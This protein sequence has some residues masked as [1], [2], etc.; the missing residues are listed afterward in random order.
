MRFLTKADMAR[1]WGV[2]RQVVNNWENRHSDFPAIE[3]TVNK[4]KLPLYLLE[5]AIKYEKKRG[6]TMELNIESLEKAIV[7]FNDWDGAAGIFLDMDDGYFEVNVYIN[8]MQMESQSP[9]DNF[10]SV[11][12]KEEFSGDKEIKEM[13]KN[14]I[15]EYS[16][17]VLDGWEP[18]QA[19]YKLADIY[20]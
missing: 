13:G 14:Y 6:I 16:K 12:S 8:T 9:S 18:M 1:R 19:Q 10:V 4:G 5:E 7:D 15:I 3:T 20:E 17:L 11:Y 2:T